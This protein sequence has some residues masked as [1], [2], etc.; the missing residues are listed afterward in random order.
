MCQISRRKKPAG[1]RYNCESAPTNF[2][3]AAPICCPPP[4]NAAVTSQNRMIR[5]RRL[6]YV[7]IKVG[8][9]SQRACFGFVLPIIIGLYARIFTD[10][11][12][13]F[14]GQSM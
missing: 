7:V 2:D 11:F 4:A 1:C 3:A 6:Y 10:G 9:V 12:M 5:K 8:G 14:R 13:F